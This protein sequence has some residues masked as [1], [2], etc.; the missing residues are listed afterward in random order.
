[1]EGPEGANQFSDVASDP[2]SPRRK[3][4]HRKTEDNED[5]EEEGGKPENRG[6]RTQAKRAVIFILASP[7]AATI[8]FPPFLHGIHTA[9]S[10]YSDGMDSKS[11][12]GGD[13]AQP[14]GKARKSHK[15]RCHGSECEYE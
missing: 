4:H 2:I 7:A 13:I 15:N 6:A 8:G 5:D 1:V 11:E 3:C 9:S 14:F 12:T 10:S